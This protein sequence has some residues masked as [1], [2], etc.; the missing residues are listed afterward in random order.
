[1]GEHAAPFGASVMPVLLSLAHCGNTT[2]QVSRSRLLSFEND[3]QFDSGSVDLGVVRLCAFQRYA[4]DCLDLAAETIPCPTL[5]LEAS[6]ILL[7][8]SSKVRRAAAGDA[9]RLALKHWPLEVVDAP[10]CRKAIVQGLVQGLQDK[11]GT[12]GLRVA[13]TRCCLSMPMSVSLCWLEFVALP[14]RL[15]PLPL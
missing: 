5:L 15:I 1:M 8:D 11:V 13:P 14:R 12:A 10:A 4:K 3:R 2:M 6:T 7:E 9:I